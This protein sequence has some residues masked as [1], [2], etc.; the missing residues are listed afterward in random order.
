MM[1]SLQLKNK[2]EVAIE[3]SK[4]RKKEEEIKE[5][6]MALGLLWGKGTLENIKICKE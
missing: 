5:R 6:K 1:L 4:Q 2:Q 3:Q